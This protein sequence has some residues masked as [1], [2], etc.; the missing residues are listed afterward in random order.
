MPLS[1][2]IL[3][4]SSAP[5][6]AIPKCRTGQSASMEIVEEQRAVERAWEALK[7]YV[8]DRDKGRCRLCGL[9]CFFGGKLSE[10][11]D[12]HHIVF[13]S[14]GGEDTKTNCLLLCR[15]CHDLIHIVKRFFLSGNADE[16]D[17][18]GKGMVRVERQV[19]GGFQV[20]GFI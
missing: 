6:L 13:Q 8:Y 19:E 7:R 15:A 5:D 12:V 20:V 9:R 11:A 17:E 1:R 2:A 3:D 10:R 18:L 4:A 14:A 16:R